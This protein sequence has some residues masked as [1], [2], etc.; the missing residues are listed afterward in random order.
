[1]KYP[2]DRAKQYPNLAGQDFFLEL[3]D[4]G[5]HPRYQAMRGIFYQGVNGVVLVHDLTFSRQA[6]GGQ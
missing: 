3:W 2:Q 6:A 5:G 4:V 1:M